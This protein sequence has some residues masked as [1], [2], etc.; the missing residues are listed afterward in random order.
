[1]CCLKVDNCADFKEWVAALGAA[2]EALSPDAAAALFPPMLDFYETPFGPQ[3][4]SREQIRDIWLEVPATHRD[5]EFQFE[6]LAF[7]ALTKLGIAHWRASFNRIP[8]GDRFKLDGIYKVIYNQ[9]GEVSEF[10]QWYNAVGQTAS[11]PSQLRSGR[12]A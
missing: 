1:M 8:D 10:R 9:K 7:D 2:W 5:V 6:V 3:V 11:N 12:L 4:T